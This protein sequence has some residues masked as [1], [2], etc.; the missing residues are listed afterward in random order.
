MI[1]S[2]LKKAMTRNF[3]DI[4]RWVFWILVAIIGILLLPYFKNGLYN[5][6]KL[7]T[8]TQH[9]DTLQPILD[10]EEIIEIEDSTA[11]HDSISITWE[12]SD[13]NNKWHQVHFKLDREDLHKSANNRSTYPNPG[14][15]IWG[16]MYKF[17]RRKL[18]SLVKAYKE[19]IGKNKLSGLEAM[20]Y[21]VSSIQ[22]I[23]YTYICDG[24]P[25]CGEAS[26][27]ESSRRPEE[28]CRPK[29]IN[30]NGTPGCCDNVGPWAVYS[31]FEFAYMKTGDCDTKALFAYTILK[32][33]GF[34]CARVI[35]GDVEAGAHAMLGIETQNA[36]YHH[37]VIHQLNGK[38][39]YAWEVTSGK[40]K[41]GQ[42]IWT[43]FRNWTVELD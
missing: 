1:N 16:H 14:P 37:H 34:S 25:G 24:N 9:F 13:Y 32:E 17:D 40:N 11:V 36:P 5:D 19:G 29:N 39:V 35:H 31:P 22:H 20:N 10:E 21:V 30:Q 8:W 4:S 26:L 15:S 23:G 33:L 41:L 27:G 12:W 6:D 42:R 38:K 2:L 43:T 28:D 3:F 7:I 18:T